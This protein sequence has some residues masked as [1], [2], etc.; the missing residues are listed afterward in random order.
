MNS[1][2]ASFLLIMI[3]TFFN[4]SNCCSEQKSLKAGCSWEKMPGRAKGNNNELSIIY[5]KETPQ[6][7]FVALAMLYCYLHRCP[8]KRRKSD[9]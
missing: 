7:Y 8:K 4:P 5:H 6:T 1:V 9:L 2:N 3:K